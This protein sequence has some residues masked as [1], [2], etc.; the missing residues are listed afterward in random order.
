MVSLGDKSYS[1]RLLHLISWSHW[2]T[3][4]NVFAAI[5]LASAYIVAEPIPESLSGQLYLVLT[6]F[7]HMS[8][9]VFIGFLLTIFPLTLIYPN[10]RVIRGVASL[11]FAVALITL[12]IDA[13]VYRQ[14]GYHLNVS[15]TEQIVNLLSQ[16]YYANSIL[17]VLAAAF[18]V[19][20]LLAFELIISNYSWKHLKQLQQTVFAKFIVM[21]LVVG[22]F[23]SHLMHISADVDLNYDI[24][25]QD[26]QFPLS[27]PATAKTLLTK[28]GFIDKNDYIERRNKPL[29]IVKQSVSYPTLDNRCIESVERLPAIIMILNDNALT[30]RQQNQFIQR[31][32]NG[33]LALNNH[34]DN[35]TESDAWFNLLFSLPT[36][37]QEQV[38]NE[39]KAPI[40]WQLYQQKNL[41]TKVTVIHGENTTHLPDWFPLLT[42]PEFTQ[43]I[44]PLLQEISPTINKIGIFV[45]YFSGTS[46]YQLELFVDAILLAQ[47]AKADKDIV[48]ISSMGNKNTSGAFG[49]KPSLITLNTSSNNV[50]LLTNNMDIQPTIL[51]NISNCSIDKS[52]Y[53]TGD[54][55]VNLKTNRTLANTMSD[56]IMLFSKDKAVLVD[57]NGSF[58]SYS[59][60]L[61]TPIAEKSDYP[62][63]IDGV[64]YIKRFGTNDKSD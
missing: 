23:V 48:W 20:G 4:F 41:P 34:V 55:L 39:A 21:A 64:N 58:Q 50:A 38:I 16:L 8:F 36:V 5:I 26:T 40:L 44:S 51:A 13:Y 22:F 53:T 31:S 27:Y 30:S 25:R 3:F 37:Y 19:F 63:L 17:F 49:A 46:D 14:L 59:T 18:I 56:G 29:S 28:Y 12:V 45:Y 11:V 33:T 7:S 47:Q 35:A 60:Q 61:Q 24:L 2:F 43:S 10:T 54:N 1:K 9:L 15:S 32:G 62:L 52:L 42:E 6:W 57:Q